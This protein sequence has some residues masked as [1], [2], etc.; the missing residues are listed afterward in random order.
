MT[1]DRIATGLE[2]LAHEIGATRE[3]FRTGIGEDGDAL[4]DGLITHGYV[5]TD[6]VMHQVSPA[7][8]NRLDASEP[9]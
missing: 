1:D 5:K 7:G 6:G 9:E 4:L 2:W 3:E 8:W